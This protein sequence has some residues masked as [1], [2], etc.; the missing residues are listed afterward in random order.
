[1]YMDGQP[2]YQEIDLVRGIAILMMITFHTLFDLNFFSVFSVEVASGFWRYFALATATL[3]LLVAGIS[4]TISRAR[5]PAQ[6][7]RAQV[8]WKFFLRGAGIFLVGLIVT[9]GTW[10]YLKEGFIFFGILHLIGI[11]VMLSPL[12]FWL[13]KRAV[14]AGLLCIIVG[15]IIAPVHGPIWLLPLG[16]HPAS[17]WSVDYEPLFPWIGCVLIGMGLGDYL[18]RDGKRQ[19]VVPDIPVIIIRSLAFLGRHSLIIYLIHQPI[20]ILLIAALTGTRIF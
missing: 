9:L 15:Y 19:F 2:R 7:T 12:F 3:F 17:F 16:I 8:F 6:V 10:I 1:M 18:Y 20:I 14:P 13:K 5:M 4:L 11:S